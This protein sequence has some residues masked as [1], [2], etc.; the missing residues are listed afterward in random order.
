MPSCKLT[1]KQEPDESVGNIDPM[2]VLPIC[3]AV[4]NGTLDGMHDSSILKTRLP[5]QARSALLD[6]VT[7]MNPE[8]V[9]KILCEVQFR[10]P[11]GKA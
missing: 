1:D 8:L 9:A 5:Q 2:L 4:V 6:M 10:V 11:N 3:S 7:G